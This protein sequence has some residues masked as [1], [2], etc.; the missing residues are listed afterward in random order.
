MQ[1][2]G[3]VHYFRTGQKASNRRGKE[4]LWKNHVP[5]IIGDMREY[6]CICV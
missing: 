1:G 4:R 2:I 5:P 3:L 6:L